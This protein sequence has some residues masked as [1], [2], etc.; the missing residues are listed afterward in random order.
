MTML[1]PRER[2][3]PGTEEEAHWNKHFNPPTNPGATPDLVTADVTITRDLAQQFDLALPFTLPNG[4]NKL[5]MW[6][7]ADRVKQFPSE[8]IIV[9]QGQVVHGVAGGRGNTHTIHWHGI[10]GTPMNDG[11]GKESFEI[12]NEYT[13][14]WT[15]DIPGTYFYH[16]HKNTP[17]HFEMGLWGGLIID[18]TQGRGFVSA[19]SPATGHVIPYD[20]EAVLA[21][22]ASDSTW[23]GLSFNAYMLRSGSPND[24]KTFTQDGVLH[25]WRPNV[26]HMTGAVAPTMGGGL[27]SSLPG[28]IHGTRDVRVG[29]TV[30]LR[31]INASFTIEEYTLGIDAQFIAQDGRAF[32]VPPHS[33]YSQP[34]VLPAGTPWRTTS[35]MRND[36]I[37]RPTAAGTY[38]FRV[39]Y[40]DWRGT[41]VLGT[42]TT[43]IV[44]R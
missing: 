15:A 4:A 35:A 11:V 39:R 10:E 20:V 44:V 21:C 43:N 5:R 26:F 27:I 18:P 9:R 36:I 33:A 29:Q 40:L 1:I 25:N 32:G 3:Q 24:P 37:I 42:V 19:F 2:I 38:P 12:S 28:V 22:S 16:C 13:Y 23:H 34:Y 17:L 8:P 7:M 6:V 14:Q 30:L 31:V 41:G